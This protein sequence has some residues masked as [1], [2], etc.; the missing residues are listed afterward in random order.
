MATFTI[1]QHRMKSNNDHN[2]NTI[3][4]HDMFDAVD[5]NDRPTTANGTTT[6]TISNQPN[7]NSTTTADTTSASMLCILT[8]D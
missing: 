8:D 1:G 3:L 4:Y 2:N 5:L 6:T 7:G